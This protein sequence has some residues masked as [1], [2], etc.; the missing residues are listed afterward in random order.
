MSMSPLGRRTLAGS[1]AAVLAS[2]AL[3]GAGVLSAANGNANTAPAA[4]G[5]E[6][7]KAEAKPKPAAKKPPS[8]TITE[9][10]KAG[11]DFRV[12]GEYTGDVTGKGKLGAQVIARG[13]TKFEVAFLVGGLP[14]DGGDGKTRTT[15]PAEAPADTPADAKELPVVTVGGGKWTGTIKGGETF[16]GKTPE[17]D[18]FTLK[19]VNRSSPTLGAKPPAGAVVLFDGTTADE[20]AGGK[21]VEQSDGKHLN[22]GVKSKKAFRDFTLHLEFRL[23]YMPDARGQGRANSGVYLQDRYECQVLDS[24]GLTGENNECGGFYQAARPA[25]NTCLPPLVWQTYDYEFTAAKFDADGKKTADAV[26]TVRLNG[27]VV[28]DKLVLKKETPGGKKESAEPGVLQFQ[29]HGNPVVF[30]NVWVVEHGK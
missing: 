27:T 22:M 3:T 2:A 29:N 14:G 8:V 7:P 19:R 13:G 9:A 21:I 28:H 16:E 15:A 20:W 25:H 1:V 23:P 30:R 17:G 24:F 10:D 18:A 12:Q 6:A 11:W 26:V 5:K 4:G